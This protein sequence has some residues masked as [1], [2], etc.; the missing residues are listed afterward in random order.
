MPIKKETRERNGKGE[1]EDEHEI[2]ST[3]DPS[4]SFS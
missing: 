2:P 4:R 3:G 1:G